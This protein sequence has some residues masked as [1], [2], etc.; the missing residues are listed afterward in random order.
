MNAEQHMRYQRQIQ[1][2]HFGAMAQTRLMQARVLIVGMGG[3]GCPVSTYLAAAGVGHLTLC[4]GDTIALSNLHRQTLYRTHDVGKLK[5]NVAAEQLQALNP[6]VTIS[7]W[8]HHF[9]IADAPRVAHFD[10]VLDCTDNFA[11]RYLINDAC[12][13]YE[14][15][16][17]SAAVQGWDG[18]FFTIKPFITPCYRCVFATPP[19]AQA[20]P[21]C[22]EQGVLGPLVGMLG[23]MQALECLKILSGR[24]TFHNAWTLVQGEHLSFHTLNM[25]RDPHCAACGENRTAFPGEYRQS[26]CAK[27]VEGVRAWEE[28]SGLRDE[29][30]DL[31][32]VDVRTHDEFKSFHIE[33]AINIPMADWTDG[34]VEVTKDK[35]LLFYCQSGK[36]SAAVY[37]AARGKGFQA[38]G[39][40]SGGLDSYAP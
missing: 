38:L 10:L 17:V 28:L 23:N 37:D 14:K 18:Q 32:L 5:V 11:T 6:N 12:I 33:G 13:H 2:P 3:L 27:A 31:L 1:L 35:R 25:K 19:P 24:Y 20:I 16:L 9:S 8:S 15:V 7:T 26:A 22:N 4:D 39:H 40:L 21:N 36:R 34:S 29:W 30:P